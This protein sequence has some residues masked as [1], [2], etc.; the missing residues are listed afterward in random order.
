MINAAIIGTGVGLKHLQAI[1]GYRKSKVKVICENNLKKLNK[2]KKLYPKIRFVKNYKDILKVESNINLISIASYDDNHFE[3]L[4]WFIKERKDII[5]EKPMVVS[6]KNLNQIKRLVSKYKV[7]IISNLVLREVDFFKKIKKIISKKKI[8]Y[9]EADYLWGR[10]NKLFEWRSKVS[11]Y[12]LTLGASIHM[13][14]IIN[15]LIEDR[16]KFVFTKGNDI[17]TKNTKFKKNSLLTHIFTYKNGLILK[18]TSNATCKYPHFHE[19]KIFEKNK[20]IILN[21]DGKKVISKNLNAKKLNFKYPDKE[22]RKKLIQK[23]IDYLLGIRKNYSPTWKEQL[24]LMNICF[25]ADRSL[26][27]KKEIKIEY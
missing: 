23:F 25:S 5:V 1:E 7:N 17:H 19:I 4:V 14:D 22:N 10:K 13:I 18:I 15:F 20:T 12:S 8:N 21:L 26:N 11:E 2:L 24:D 27:K 16:P 9:I 3:Q 6:I